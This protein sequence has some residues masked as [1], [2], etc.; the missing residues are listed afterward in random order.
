MLQRIQSAV[1]MIVP[2]ERQKKEKKLISTKLIKNIFNEKEYI[3]L[4]LFTELLRHWNHT[5]VP[6]GRGTKISS[7]TAGAILIYARI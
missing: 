6:K 4:F 7:P 5:I 2:K 3:L 1:Q